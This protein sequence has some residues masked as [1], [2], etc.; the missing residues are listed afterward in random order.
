MGNYDMKVY[1]WFMH[2]SVEL[3]NISFIYTNFYYNFNFV[4]NIAIVKS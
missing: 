3:Y 4:V 2:P 1:T